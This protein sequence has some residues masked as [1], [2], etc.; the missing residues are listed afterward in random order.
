[1]RCICVYIY[2]CLKDW[3]R[4]PGDS[5]LHQQH[6]H[7]GSHSRTLHF[8]LY[9]R[10]FLALDGSLSRNGLP[11]AQPLM[12]DMLEGSWLQHRYLYLKL[13]KKLTHAQLEARQA[14]DTDEPGTAKTHANSSAQLTSVAGARND[15]PLV[16]LK[17]RG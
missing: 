16:R 17:L 4:I 14:L 1:M 10:R 11:Y 9:E 2:I 6:T 3:Q 7:L 13:K 8:H 5:C 12:H 15:Q